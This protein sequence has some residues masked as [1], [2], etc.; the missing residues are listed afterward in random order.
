MKK[1][2]RSDD[3]GIKSVGVETCSNVILIITTTICDTGFTKCM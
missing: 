1:D 2:S 3:D